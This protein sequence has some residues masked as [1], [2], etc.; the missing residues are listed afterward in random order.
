MNAKYNVCMCHNLTS[1]NLLYSTILG[2][3][4]SKVFTRSYTWQDCVN[5][6]MARLGS[7]GLNLDI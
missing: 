7:I 4:W 1:M 5:I 2:H 6:T 3:F